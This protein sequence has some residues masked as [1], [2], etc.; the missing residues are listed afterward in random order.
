MTASAA[1]EKPLR[2]AFVDLARGIALAAM[3]VYHATWDLTLVGLLPEAVGNHPA[4]VLFA[5]SIATSFLVLVGVSLVL[6]TRGPLD[7]RAYLRRLAMVAGAALL[8]T[9]GTYFAF[10]DRFVFFGILHH[11]ALA[12]VIA[13]PFLRLPTLLVLAAAA[14]M[15]AAPHVLARPLFNAPWLTPLGLFT[16]APES[17]DFV[18]ILPWFGAVLAGIAIGRMLADHVP[19]RLGAWRPESRLSRLLVRAGRWSLAVYLVHQPLLFALLMPL[20][21]AIGPV[22]QPFDAQALLPDCQRQCVANGGETARC[23]QVCRCVVDRLGDASFRATLP[24][25]RITEADRDRVAGVVAV[26]N[27]A[28]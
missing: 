9:I 24:S 6:A 25:G 20:A 26:C 23:A 11:I 5:R 28:P 10:P 15:A 13:L 7:G 3:I 17:V 12:S 27:L 16:T 19:E 4:L 8:V 22:Q 14:L 2:L 18:P 1:S 21:W